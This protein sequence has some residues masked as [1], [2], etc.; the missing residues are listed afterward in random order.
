MKIY[1]EGKGTS[2]PDDVQVLLGQS[3]ESVTAHQLQE[4]LGLTPLSY[5]LWLKYGF[6]AKNI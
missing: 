3:P 5:E 2:M 6:G 4:L 1:C